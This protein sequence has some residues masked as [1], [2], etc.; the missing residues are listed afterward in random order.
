MSL[1]LMWSLNVAFNYFTV[2]LC[3]CKKYKMEY[4]LIFKTLLLC[5][6]IIFK[7]QQIYLKVVFRFHISIYLKG[8]FSVWFLAPCA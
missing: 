5:F 4:E 7:G 6:K 1:P 3:K 8:Q 2:L